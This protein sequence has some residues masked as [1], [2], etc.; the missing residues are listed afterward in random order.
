[1][2]PVSCQQGSP[3]QLAIQTYVFPEVV[4]DTLS[5][6]FLADEFRKYC[7]H[8]N[9]D[10]GFVVEN[11]RRSETSSEYA[12]FVKSERERRPFL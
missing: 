4:L 7:G 8:G 5:E 12:C 9:I 2:D 10:G 6:D 1:M 11:G 3:P